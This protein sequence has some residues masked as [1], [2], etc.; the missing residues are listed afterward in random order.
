[1]KP[2]ATRIAFGCLFL[3]AVADAFMFND[4]SM[5]RHPDLS[6]V[7]E[8]QR[9]KELTIHIEV[10]A[11]TDP[12]NKKQQQ[13]QDQATSFA[14]R[15][16]RV[17]MD[18]SPADNDNRVDLPG[19]DG[20]YPSV[21]SGARCL[22]LRK[23]GEFIT[24]EGKRLVDAHKCCWELLWKKDAIAG[25][26]LMGMEIPEEQQRSEGSAVLPK[27][28]VY[29]NFLA[30]T[31]ESLDKVRK[32]QAD[33]VEKAKKCLERR[34]SEMAQMR[35]THNPFLKAL[36]Y[37]NAFAAIESYHNE[38]LDHYEQLVPKEGEILELQDGIFLSTRGY[39]WTKHETVGPNE[40]LG[41]ARLGLPAPAT[42]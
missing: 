25:S 9:P 4:Q 19:H 8:K 3:M 30:W 29:L 1:M 31:K 14:I 20:P 27:G 40:F 21:S 17:E 35:E 15:D 26:F 18:P 5:V 28:K 36:H 7:M 2:A 16:F 13:N 33:A 42:N 41:T 23:A 12:K 39:L 24:I 32:K 34:D 11:T 38:P 6:G 22:T 10:G 37:R